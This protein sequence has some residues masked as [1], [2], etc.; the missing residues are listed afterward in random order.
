MVKHESISRLESSF[1][2]GPTHQRC[3]YF[4]KTVQNTSQT[5]K[6]YFL[7]GYVDCEK[8]TCHP[9]VVVDTGITGGVVQTVFQYFSISGGG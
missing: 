1:K 3:P 5:S 7:I 2:M 6:Q 8:Q 9:V 4:P